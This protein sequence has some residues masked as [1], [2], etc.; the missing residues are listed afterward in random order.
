LQPVQGILTPAIQAAQ[1]N[2]PRSV[3]A[4]LTNPIGAA[5]DQMTNAGVF[6]PNQNSF[7]SPNNNG[8]QQ[9]IEVNIHP[10]AKHLITA[11]VKSATNGF[12][13]G[14]VPLNRQP[15]MNSIMN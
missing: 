11:A 15:G 6:A 3:G 9:S 14:Q 1:R 8:T 7:P 13:N 5:V 10:N 2:M 4:Y 12:N